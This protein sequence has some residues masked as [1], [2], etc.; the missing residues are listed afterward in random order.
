MIKLIRWV[1]GIFLCLVSLAGFAENDYLLA[2]V[3]LVGG[4]FT[5]PFGIKKMRLK[6]DP[7]LESKKSTQHS[8]SLQLIADI[9][10]NINTVNKTLQENEIIDV[11]GQE[12]K[13]DYGKFSIEV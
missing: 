3:V 8:P 4:L 2:I 13:I 12:Q 5:L 10:N 6:T 1:I 9:S 11:T 7:P